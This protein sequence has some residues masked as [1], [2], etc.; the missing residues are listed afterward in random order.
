M[1]LVYLVAALV[2]AFVAGAYSAVRVLGFRESDGFDIALLRDE[3]REREAEARG[4]RSK[5]TVARQNEKALAAD[6]VRLTRDLRDAR[7]A[8]SA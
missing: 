5:L 6:V 3:L 4:L 8:P 1:A 2:A 7:K